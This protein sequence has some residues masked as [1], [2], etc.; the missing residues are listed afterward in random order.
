MKRSTSMAA[1]IGTALALTA[2]APAA[3]NDWNVTA[4][5]LWQDAAKWT[6]G[7]APDASDTVRIINADNKTVT[8]NADTPEL[9]LTVNALT[10]S[11]GAAGET[12]SLLIANAVAP[13]RLLGA[14]SPALLVG[15]SAGQVGAVQISDCTLLS[16][17]GTTARIDYIGHSGA[18]RVI[19]QDGAVWLANAIDVGRSAGSQGTLSIDGGTHYLRG[20]LMVGRSSG[21]TGTVTLTG[22]VLVSS[23]ANTFVGS[24]GVGRMHMTGGSWLAKAVYVGYLTGSQGT[25]DIDGGTNRIE[26]ISLGDGA[27][28][29]G[30]VSL[31]GGK[32]LMTGTP[33]IGNFGVGRVTVSNGTLEIGGSGYINLGY[34]TGTGAITV[35][36]PAGHLVMTN[37]TTFIGRSAGNLCSVTN[38][39]GTWLAKLVYIGNVAGSRGTVTIAGGS[40][41]ISGDL[42]LA[43]NPSATGTLALAGGQLVTMAAATIGTKGTAE[44]AVSGGTWLANAISVG[45]YAGSKGVLTI[46]GGKV[47]VSDKIQL[48]YGSATAHSNTTFIAGG[49]LEA[50]F[51]RIFPGT[52]GNVISNA[53]GVYQFTTATP[54]ITPN[55]GVIA[56]NGSTVS[57]RNVTGVNVK[58]NWS[59]T[60]LKKMTFI[61]GGKNAFRLDAS[62]T[63]STPDQSYTFAPALGATNYTRLELWNGALYRG[64]NVVIGSGGSLMVTGGVSAIEGDLSLQPG[65]I[66]E[67]TIGAPA[68][69]SRLTV[70]GD[71]A[72]GNSLLRLNLS[73]APEEYH[74][75][76]IIANDSPNPVSGGFSS[77]SATAS[78]GG[79]DYTFAISTH[80]GDGNDVTLQWSDPHGTVIAIR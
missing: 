35:A 61:A 53:G 54:T 41:V 44:L 34:G 37:G 49:L 6:Q 15:N 10:V 21:A 20:G 3:N 22:G 12:N 8:I 26:S 36:G 74:P 77:G 79:R 63:A 78:F 51:M 4:D 42:T 18:G 76:V 57:F 58:G 43:P 73:R 75:Y 67:V 40:T 1:A 17:N 16:T 19:L 59:G 27:A 50:N 5:G 70:G 72:L 66:A 14:A 64:G 69:S 62:T 56:I 7:R 80:G 2:P 38:S 68:S 55:S 47:L 39:G 46:A 33:T 25:L 52:V 31:T 24:S 11:S 48:G 29:M 30:T 28:S 60:D 32:L 13:L 23:N 65:A 71:V 9:N 45:Y